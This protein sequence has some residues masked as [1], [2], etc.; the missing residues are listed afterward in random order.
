MPVALKRSAERCAKLV[1]VICAL[2]EIP[3]HAEGVVC[4]ERLVTEE[5]E[6]RAARGVGARLGDDVDDRPTGASVLRRIGVR[7]DLK[8]LHGILAE[9]V[10]CTARS[11]PSD[12]LSEERVVI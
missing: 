3:L 8:F 6:G 10:G 4:I 12:R 2:G 5:L 1:V 7:V 9:L 11:G